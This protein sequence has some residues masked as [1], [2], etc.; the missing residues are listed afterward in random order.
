MVRVEFGVPGE[1]SCHRKRFPLSFSPAVHM[2]LK[3]ILIE[4]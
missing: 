4:E 2:Y 3:V 1:Y